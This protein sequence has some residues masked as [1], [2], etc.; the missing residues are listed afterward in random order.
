MSV[1]VAVLV[2]LAAGLIPALRAFRADAGVLMGHGS[3]TAGRVDRRLRA[4]LVAVQVA[5]SVVLLVGAGLLTRTVLG[6]L[7]ANTGTNARGVVTM[8]LMLTGSAQFDAASRQPFVHELL[9]EVRALPGVEH[10][11]LGG[12]LPPAVGA[13]ALSVRYTT[14]TRG[15]TR[16]RT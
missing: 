7:D 13:L 2:A 5:L 4:G 15:A 9:R 12:S 6:L 16:R 14:R 3:R 10:A 1:A 11:G 8:R